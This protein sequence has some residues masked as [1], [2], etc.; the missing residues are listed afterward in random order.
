[1]QDFSRARAIQSGDLVLLISTGSHLDTSFKDTNMKHKVL[2]ACLI[3]D[4][5]GASVSLS[6]SGS[7]RLSVVH[8]KM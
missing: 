6:I 8:L 4:L 3:L 7:L 5:C 2:V 1:M